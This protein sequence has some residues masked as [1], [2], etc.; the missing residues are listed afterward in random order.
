ME[1]FFPFPTEFP[2]FIWPHDL[3]GWAVFV[4]WIGIIGLLIWHWRRYNLPLRGGQRWLLLGLLAAEI[5][6]SFSM[7]VELPRLGALPFPAQPINPPGTVLLVFGAVPWFLAAGFLGPAYAA[8]LA[9]ISGIV[10]AYFTTY[11]P[12]LVFEFALLGTVL[13]FLLRQRYRT[14]FFASVRNPLVAALVLIPLFGAVYVMNATVLATGTVVVSLDY[15]LSN[16]PAMLLAVGGS[17]LVGAV[18]AQVLMWFKIRGW[19]ASGPLE[20]SPSERSLQ[21]RFLYIMIPIGLIV[22]V[23]LIVGDWFISTQ[24]A[25]RMLRDRMSNAVET[26]IGSVPLFLEAGQDLIQQISQ[27]ERLYEASNNALPAVLRE[28]MRRIPF[29]SQLFYIPFGQSI[30]VGYQRNGASI[31]D[32]ENSPLDEKQGVELAFNGV[33]VQSYTIPP[34]EGQ[35]AAQ[36]TFIASVLDGSGTTRGAVVGRVE[37]GANPFTQS[38]INSLES[39][40]DVDGQGYLLDENGIVLYHSMPGKV[41]SI[42]P[43]DMAESEN[44][45]DQTAEDGTRSL[46]YFQEAIGRPWAAA[47][48]VPARQSQ[49]LSLGFV[50]P[51]L[52]MLVVLSIV[53]IVMARFG[54]RNVTNSLQTLAVE[55]NRIARGNLDSPL[56]LGG[57][58]EVGQLTRSFEQMR[59][60]LK[61]RLEELNQ[62]LTVSAG[63]ASSLDLEESL[64]PVIQAA[65]VNGADA[66]HIVLNPEA[67]AEISQSPEVMPESLHAGPAREKYQT[68]HSQLLTLAS[69]QDQI[70]LTN[71]ARVR[72]LQF[73]NERE[74]PQ[75]LAVYAL[76]HENQYFGVLWM[77]FDRPHAFSD[78][79]QR[80]YTTLASQA[81]VAAAN[82]S[83]F[84]SAEIGRQRLAAIL[85]STPDPILVTDSQNRLLLVNPAARKAFGT[86]RSLAR[87]ENID[88]VL[89]TEKLIALLQV[90]AADRQSAEITLPDARTYLAIGS[91]T[92]M[93]GQRAGRVCVMRDI[94]HFKELDTLKSEFVSTVSHDLRSPLTLIHGYATMLQMVGELN[95]QQA[96]YAARIISGIDNMNRLVSNLLDLGRIEAGV[97]L[98]LELLPLRDIIEQVSGSLQQQATQKQM[99]LGVN[100]PEGVEPIV[101]ADPALLQQA[102]HNLVENAI[103]YT[104]VGGKVTAG[105]EMRDEDVLIFVRDNGIGIAP[106]DQTR[107][108]EKFFR[109]ARRGVMQ[110]RGTGLGLAIV[111]S[112]A[113]RHN[114]RVWVESQLGQG[115]TF[116]LLLPVRQSRQAGQGGDS[117][118]IPINKA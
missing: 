117:K 111:K 22:V 79:E 75:A 104:E 55:S 51:L 24:A 1:F 20:L 37:L 41:M 45:G 118:Q 61:A 116:Y 100:F 96:N 109:V 54:I 58:D 88:E 30:G 87:G 68:L 83:L 2:R 81:S 18:A 113:E 72:L 40:E 114:G 56:V 14:R 26:S 82:A 49:Q 25:R 46:V 47:L 67:F 93:N 8:G 89:E 48:W 99:K 112:I 7:G 98:K 9:A 3:I 23:A 42:Y 50:A 11:N 34:E 76:W 64:R 69:E 74:R 6:L 78:E 91:T 86:E 4:L 66:A 84:L 77:A 39:L 44:F 60:S 53:T 32:L 12:F 97:G 21:A 43:G 94:T 62:L 103:K 105:F 35:Q 27:D 19:G 17:I 10:L 65:V 102:L 15:A 73:E 71:P 59:R 90:D 63:A 38:I 107:L 36:V 16:A 80:F 28:N 52:L 92:M 106:V 115:S 110:R 31:Y 57:Q 13:G 108:F 29:F 101:E 95:D 5:L 85:E 33:E 70:I